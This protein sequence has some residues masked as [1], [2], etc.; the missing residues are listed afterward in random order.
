MARPARPRVQ[1][2]RTIYRLVGECRDLGD[3]PSAWRRHALAG[4]LRL[5]DADL[6]IGGELAGLTAG[7]T[8][9]LGATEVGWENGFDRRG[10]VRALELQA[11][12]PT[13]SPLMLGYAARG[14]WG[15]SLR[16][17][18]LVGERVWERSAE[19]NE[20]YRVVG[21]DHALYCFVPVPGAAGEVGGAI[22]TR[23][24][25]RRDFSAREAA[26]VAEAFAAVG[27]LVGGPLARFADPSPAALPPRVRQVLRC[28]LEGEGDKQIARRLG[29]SGHT[30][31]QY[32]KAILA[33]FGCQ[34]RAELLA[35]WV[36]R[37]W[38]AKC[39]WADPDGR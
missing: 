33:H 3:D 38:G 31:N 39:A 29:I 5:V 19:R 11:T 15:K 27:P 13:S 21:V 1:D 2:V 28:L 17:T 25:G 9:D 34:S 26:I 35:R 6:G 22:L 24:A 7:Q 14:G 23:A 8:R 20:V 12:D 10:W 30:V 16:R 36:R 18:E 4:L 37:G 32:A